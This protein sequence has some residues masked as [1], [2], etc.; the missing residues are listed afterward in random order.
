[1]LSGFNQPPPLRQ[2]VIP[3]APVPGSN[4][5]EWDQLNPV[6]GIDLLVSTILDG[7]YG[8]VASTAGKLG[9]ED[10]ELRTV[11]LTVFEVCLSLLVGHTAYIL[12]GL[13]E[14]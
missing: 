1:M 6:Q 10:M 9:K 11:A 13:R 5:E 12:I 3:Y 2:R 8:G 4:G 7:E 14:R